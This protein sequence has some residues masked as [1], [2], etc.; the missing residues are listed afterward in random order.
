MTKYTIRRIGWDELILLSSNIYDKIKKFNLQ[1]DTF[2]PILR[3]GMPLCLLLGKYIQD[4]D[5]SC[6]HIRRSKSNRPNAE[7]GETIFKGI[8]NPESITG[9]NIMIVEDI[10]DHGLSLDLAIEKIKE[11]NPKNIYIST[12]FNFN[13]DK[14]KDVISGEQLDNYYW[15]MFPWDGE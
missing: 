11:Y 10:I 12:F 4:A 3:G 7:F 15:I 5:V 13:N 9:K 8:T 2:V 6:V 1:I 14:Y